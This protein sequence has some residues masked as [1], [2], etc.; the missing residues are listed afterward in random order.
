MSEVR[1][2]AEAKLVAC[3]KCGA[4]A[5]VRYIN[6]P[7]V[8]VHGERVMPADWTHVIECRFCGILEQPDQVEK[9][10]A[11]VPMSCDICGAPA[12]RMIQHDW[13]LPNA[14]FWLLEQYDGPWHLC[15]QHAA[16]TIE[17]STGEREKD[18]DESE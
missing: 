14:I 15:D 2:S 17:P 12:T 9:P 4:C 10:P 13:Q 16:G 5:I 1:M 11:K 8:D 18:A 3:A 6:I 7:Y